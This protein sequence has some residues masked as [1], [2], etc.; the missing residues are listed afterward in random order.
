MIN[1]DIGREIAPP[2]NLRLAQLQR[3][4]KRHK[5]KRHPVHHDLA[6]IK[7]PET[8]TYVCEIN[9]WGA[10]TCPA[11]QVTLTPPQTRV[12]VS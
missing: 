3:L 5:I 2:I 11:C 9:R 4:A 12:A 10:T 7:C 8:R 6:V 1:Q